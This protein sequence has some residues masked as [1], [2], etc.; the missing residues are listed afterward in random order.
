MVCSTVIADCHVVNRQILSYLVTV[1]VMRHVKMNYP[2]E[3]EL[4]L[5]VI[6]AFLSC[7]EDTFYFNS[8]VDMLSIHIIH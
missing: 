3:E 7:Q 5:N 1:Y 6:K 2:L 4:T 8:K